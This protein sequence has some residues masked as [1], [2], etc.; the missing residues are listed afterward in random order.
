MTKLTLPLEVGKKYVCRDGT[1]VD[2]FAKAEEADWVPGLAHIRESV[3]GR[4]MGTIWH[5]TGSNG[6]S[7]KEF[8]NDVIADYV[9]VT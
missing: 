2:C 7:G 5:D 4:S 1:I 8:R 3:S 9:E 6:K